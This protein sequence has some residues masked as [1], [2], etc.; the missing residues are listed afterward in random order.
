MN[1]IINY[2]L[3]NRNT[4]KGRKANNMDLIAFFRDE[5]QLQMEMQGKCDKSAFSGKMGE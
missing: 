2:N 1:K 4:T 3:Y 5:Y